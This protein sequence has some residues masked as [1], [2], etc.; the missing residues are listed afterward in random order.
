MSIGVITLGIGPGEITPFVLTGLYVVTVVD[1]KGSI[2]VA[3]ASIY[4]A[5]LTDASIYAAG[6]GDASIYT[7][8]PGDT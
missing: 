7:A 3:D 8:A 5:A 1:V 4:G 2:S 6:P